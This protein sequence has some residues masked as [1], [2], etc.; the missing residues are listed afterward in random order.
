MSASPSAHNLDR[1]GPPSEPSPI[2]LDIAGSM[3]PQFPVPNLDTDKEMSNAQG[4]ITQSPPHEPPAQTPRPNAPSMSF[5][6]RIPGPTSYANALKHTAQQAGNNPLEEPSDGG[7]RPHKE[8]LEESISQRWPQGAASGPIKGFCAKRIMEN[9]NP[10]VCEAWEQEVQ[11][12]IFVHYP[13][14]GYDFSMALNV[15]TIADDLESEQTTGMTIE[16]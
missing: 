3:I 13:D 1:E 2:S 11:D 8:A 6:V 15:H 12:A 10:V 4:A 5:T 7:E 16:G 9:L 14:G